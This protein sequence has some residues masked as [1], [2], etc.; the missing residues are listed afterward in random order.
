MKRLMA[1]LVMLSFTAGIGLIYAEEQMA[2]PE[3][4]KA[5]PSKT[6]KPAAKAKKKSMSI[7]GEVVAVD[8][9]NSQ[10]TIKNEKKGETQIVTVDAKTKLTKED[11]AIQLSELAAGTKVSVRYRMEAE[12]NIA[13]SIKVKV[14]KPA[15]KAKAKAAEPVKK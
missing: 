14:P 9:A 8:I 13:T 6:I 10:V 3:A 12:K 4:V 11:K 15:A 7:T 5:A 2:K 1:L